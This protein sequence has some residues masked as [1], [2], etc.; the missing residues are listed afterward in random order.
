MLHGAE[1]SPDNMSFDA[2]VSEPSEFIAEVRW[3]WQQ[4]THPTGNLRATET[5]A[6]KEREQ[7]TH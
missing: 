5:A 6:G 2:A 7:T 4:C 3:L 1:V